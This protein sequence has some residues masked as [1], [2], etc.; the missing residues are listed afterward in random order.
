MVLTESE[1]ETVAPG[2]GKA[3]TPIFGMMS[4]NCLSIKEDLED[5]GDEGEES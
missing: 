4:P 2:K 5:I 3:G 1:V